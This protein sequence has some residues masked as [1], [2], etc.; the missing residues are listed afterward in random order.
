M[1]TDPSIR[2]L[3]RQ[4]LAEFLDCVASAGKAGLDE[5]E[6]LRRAEEISRSFGRT[7]RSRLPE[8][9]NAVLRASIAGPF[10]SCGA[11]GGDG[12]AGIGGEGFAGGFWFTAAAR[13]Q[14]EGAIA[15]MGQG[16]RG[17][18]GADAAGVLGESA[19]FDA[20]GAVLDAPMG[21]GGFEE[22]GG[23]GGLLRQIGNGI[24]DLPLAVGLQ[25]AEALDA[26]DPHQAGPVLVE[27]RRWRAHR[28]AADLDAAVLLADRLGALQVR[29]V[30]P[31][32]RG[33]RQ[34]RDPCGGKRRQR[35]VRSRPGGRA[36]WL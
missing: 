36:G 10:N 32:V 1:G 2:Y 24:D 18:A 16:D 29:R 27:P 14:G 26:A 4:A 7:A 5:L 33:A 31:P 19:V 11:D 15:Q 12:G 25:L 28:D 17:V 21:A 20:E 8:A 6:R 23:A 35:R 3:C 34:R 22:L 13:D 30:D 9:A